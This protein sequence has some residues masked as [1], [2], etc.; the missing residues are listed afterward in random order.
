MLRIHE[1]L[2]G[3]WSGSG[4][5]YLWII[6][7]DAD[8]NPV[9]QSYVFPKF[10]FSFLFEGTFTSF[11]KDKKSYRSHKTVRNN[12]FLTIFVRWRMDP[13]PDPYLWLMDPDPYLWLMDPDPVGPKT[14]GS[15]T[16]LSTYLY[17]QTG[18][19]IN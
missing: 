19:I 3:S 14:C 10:F 18:Q 15:A 9:I 7:P 13:D 17:P 4:D 6:D 1:I 11:F 16:L 12:V 5:P 2:N 8:P